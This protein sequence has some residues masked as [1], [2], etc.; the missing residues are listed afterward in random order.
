VTVKQ[1]LSLPPIINSDHSK[2]SLATRNVFIEVTAT[3][4]NKAHVVL[5]VPPPIPALNI[6]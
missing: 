4:A 6:L 2:I 3:D 5:S 1:V